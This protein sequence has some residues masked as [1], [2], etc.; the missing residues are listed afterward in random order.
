MLEDGQRA[1]DRIF[2]NRP[3]SMAPVVKLDDHA[4]DG[5]GHES[6]PAMIVANPLT[7]LVLDSFDTTCSTRL[8]RET[9]IHK[10]LEAH[11]PRLPE[12]TA[13]MALEEKRLELLHD[14]TSDAQVLEATLNHHRGPP[15]ISFA[16]N[17]R[18]SLRAAAASSAERRLTHRSLAGNRCRQRAICRTQKCNLD[19][20]RL[21]QHQSAKVWAG[22]GFRG[23]NQFNALGQ[24]EVASG[25]V[26]E[27]IGTDVA[28][29]DWPST[30]G[31]RGAGGSP[32][33]Y[34]HHTRPDFY[35]LRTLR[36]VN[37]SSSRLAPQTGAGFFAA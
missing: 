15:A 5:A 32:R 2:T 3:I 19:R 16:D 22:F 12:P 11:G 28:M 37:W 36:Q 1:V 8:S 35:R 31:S 27:T 23:L 4:N 30:P 17:G 6:D 26:R 24:R 13:L 10:F 34:R 29:E 9:E 7:I 21:S 33:K 20:A 25:F 14:Y 18:R